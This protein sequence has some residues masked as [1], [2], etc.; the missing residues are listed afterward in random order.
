MAAR[1][2]AAMLVGGKTI[3]HYV[4][5]YHARGGAP[6]PGTVVIVDEWSEVQLHIWVELARWGLMSVKFILLG[7]ADGQ[8]KPIFDKWAK[9]MKIKDIRTSRFIHEL[10]GI[11]Q[12]TIK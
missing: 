12:F 4:H 5:K 1:H 8:R 6:A 9:A 7:D 3:S 2:A 11:L 10:C